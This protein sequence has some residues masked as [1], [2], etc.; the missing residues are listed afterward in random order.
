MLLK[1]AYY[2]LSFFQIEFDKWMEDISCRTASPNLMFR[3]SSLV[4]ILNMR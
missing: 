1:N 3:F 4:N 2:T